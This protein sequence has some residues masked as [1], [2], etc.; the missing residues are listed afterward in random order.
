LRGAGRAV[1]RA[2]LGT[3]KPFAEDLEG[4][5][6]WYD[7]R[8]STFKNYAQLLG[9]AVLTAGALTSFAQAFGSQA[10][11]R[12]LTAFLGG[13]V[14]IAEGWQQIARS[15]ETWTAY[16]IA[17][18]RMKRER[19]LYVNGAGEYRRLADEE[20]AITLR[21][22]RHFLPVTLRAVRHSYR[23]PI[24]G[25]LLAQHRRSRPNS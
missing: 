22:V 25:R 11:V 2:G 8:A 5:H 3:K 18:E 24:P 9:L 19:R 4:R 13:V 15:A 10:W 20:E 21:A 7:Q 16:R 1:T 6:G 12:I 14:V 17:T 23:S